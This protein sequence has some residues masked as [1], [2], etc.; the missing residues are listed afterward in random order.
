[1]FQVAHWSDAEWDSALDR[2]VVWTGDDHPVGVWGPYNYSGWARVKE[3]DGWR[4]LRI[5]DDSGLPVA[6]TLLKQKGP[7]VVAYA[8]GGFVCKRPVGAR[9]YVSLLRR[10]TGAMLLYSRTHMMIPKKYSDPDRLGAGW[11]PVSH[12]LGA[13]LTLTMRLDLAESERREALSFNWRRNLRRSEQHSN[14]FSIEEHPSIDDIVSLQEELGTLKG[15]HVISWEASRSHVEKLVRSFGSRLVVAKCVSE[16]GRLRSIRGAIITGGCAY[17][18][19]AATSLEGR[20]HYASHGTLWAL[21]NELAKRGAVRYDLGGVDAENNRGVYDFKNGT[22]ATEVTYGGE[23]DVALPTF[24][25]AV[26]SAIA[27]RFR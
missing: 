5:I 7:A 21:A 26:I 16:Q 4:H 2:V 27:L 10:E 23:F 14:V 19:L 18:M 22:G 13:R 25:R 6:Q 1:M 17:D 3:L 24:S 9:D 20:K 8:P 15:G 12:H 11:V